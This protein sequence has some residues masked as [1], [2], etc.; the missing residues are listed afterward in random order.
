[1]AH[2][3]VVDPNEGFAMLLVEELQKQGYTVTSANTY[4]AAL[5]LAGE[6]RPD[7]A[8][9]DMGLDSPGTVEL[10][11]QLRQLHDSL[12]LVLIPLMGEELS[13]TVAAEL[14][15]QG[16]LPKPF[17]LPELPDR[18]AGAF[19]AP[20]NGESAVS[21]DVL[22]EVGAVAVSEKTTV[23]PQEAVL[24]SANGT[25]LS[26]KLL[27]QH[28]RDVHELMDALVQEVSADAVLLTVNNQLSVSVGQLDKDEIEVVAQ[29]VIQGWKTSAEMARIL[30]REQVR[31]EQSIAGGDYMLYALGVDTNAILA[32]VIRGSA[33]LGL[34][35]HRARGVADQIAQICVA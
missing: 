32:V 11:Q 1:M 6:Q 15:I 18:I 33:A 21:S 34:L 24:E 27:A 31:F 5:G 19:A 12:R 7:L 25:E 10:A 13:P 16:V 2:I 29:A 17:F 28:R 3:L 4:E 30:G 23:E 22:P 35:R 8:L 9:L 20:L 26:S 14:S